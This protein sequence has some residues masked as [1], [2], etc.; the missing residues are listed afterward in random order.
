[1]W[2]V[3]KN[4]KRTVKEPAT[5]IKDKDGNLLEEPQQIKERYKEHFTDI[6]QPPKA[7]DDKEKQQ[8]DI[9]NTAFRNIMKLAKEQ[10]PVLT[11]AQEVEEAVHELRTGKCKDESG[12]CNEMIL[13]GG[14]EMIKSLLKLF[15]MM[16]LE[17]TVPSQWNEVLIKTVPKP[18]SVLLLDNKRGLFI[19]EIISKI[20]EKVIKRRN[21]TKINQHLSC[22]QTGGVKDRSSTDNIFV[23]SE[24][25]RRNKKLGLKT[26][27]VFGDAVRCFDK[28]WLRDCLVELHRA[29]CSP[30]DIHM[31]YEMNK[32]TSITI[33]TPSGK[34]ETIFIGEV[35][36]Q[37]T[38]LGPTLCS[39]ET[40]QIN[41]I[42]ENQDRNIG[43]QVV[44]ILVFVDDIMSAGTADDARRC[45]RNMRVMEVR[46]KFSYG[47]KK[48]KVMVINTG[49]EEKEKIEEQVR[50]GYVTYCDK[51]KY[52][53]LWVN[54]EGN[55]LMH[56]E[57][58]KEIMKGE[59]VALKSIANYHNM[60][61]A[62]LNVRLELYKSCA[63]KSI[64]FNLEGWNQLTKKEV[65][66]LENIQAM[67]L[68]SLL[69]I[70]KT[71]PYIGLLNELGI[72][73]MEK[74]I[75]YRKLMFYHNMLNSDDRRLSK[76]IVIEQEV[77]DDKDTFYMNVQEMASSIGLCLEL[78]KSSTKDELKNTIKKLINASM[79]TT[80]I[81]SLKMSK[82]RFVKPPE[83][84]CAKKFL[85][86][87]DGFDAIQVI[88]T[89]LN[90]IPI[91]GN[92]KGDLTLPRLCTWCEIE[93]DTTEHILTCSKMAVCN[94]TPEHL[95]NDDNPDL[96]KVINTIVEA[97]LGARRKSSKTMDNTRRYDRN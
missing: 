40:D 17:K 42:G 91:Y 93:D 77:L 37:G 29:G 32:D 6:L 23:L 72:W 80:V 24:I 38:V 50:E 53:G 81:D 63:A 58:K 7:T 79:V 48:T 75:V 28:L 51:Y 66:K 82:L 49:R 69:S 16:E 15:N 59:M 78:V 4:I 55:C 76:R 97:N 39:V 74:Q 56:M 64:L 71:T 26:Y 3:V 73:T 88:K 44:G 60:G 18:G 67:C 12:W 25:I 33:D 11:R 19:T 45:I 95:Q 31:I 10:I 65:D 36:K 85:V 89:R 9:I 27:V 21:Q 61:P 1:M 92:Y 68:C 84:F 22:Y 87:M 94:I 47:L 13:N 34:T 86:E 5:A 41:N 30:Q 70:P 14:P 83:S 43:D 57:K 2:E 8:E 96:W 52:V 20:Y 35:V 90:M 62:F 54:E 46:K